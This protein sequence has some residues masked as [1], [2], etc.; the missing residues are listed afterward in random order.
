GYV[1]FKVSDTSKNMMPVDL[2]MMGEGFHNNHHTH[3]NRANFAYKWYEIDPTYQA[4][5]VFNLLGIIKLPK[6]TATAATFLE[7]RKVVNIAG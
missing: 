1:T 5:K 4:I 3:G 2:F 7:N 6:K